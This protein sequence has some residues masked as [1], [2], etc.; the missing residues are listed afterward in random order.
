MQFDNPRSGCCF[1]P[2]FTRPTLAGVPPANLS[3]EV[4]VDIVIGLAFLMRRMRLR[5]ELA[6]FHR[7]W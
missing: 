3:F 4:L 6:D 2:R 5:V 1:E 7:H